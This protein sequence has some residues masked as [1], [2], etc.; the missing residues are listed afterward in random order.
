M[1]QQNQQVKSLYRWVLRE[2]QVPT[3]LHFSCAICFLIFSSCFF[4]YFLLLFSVEAALRTFGSE[5]QALNYLVSQPNNTNAA[6]AAGSVGAD[7]QV[8]ES[9]AEGSGGTDSVVAGHEAGG[10]SSQKER[11]ERD[12][13]MEDELTGELENADAYS[14]Y[15]IEVTKEG[16]AINEY[17]ALISSAAE[18]A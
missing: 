5:E 18:N 8:G 1:K 10:S 3:F 12:L 14:D 13:E 2:H 17:L 4:I 11:E 15:D 6:N 16:E 7:H 9:N